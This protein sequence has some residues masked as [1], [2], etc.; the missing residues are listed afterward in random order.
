MTN[1]TIDLLQIKI[2]QAKAQLPAETLN[3]I[4]AVDWKSIILGL[5]EKKGYTF[6]QLGD[7]E[8][9]TELLLCG[10]ISTGDYT[11]EL[12]DRMGISEGGASELAKEMNDLVFRKIRE[13]LIKNEERKKTFQKSETESTANDALA[14]Q[15]SGI[16]IIRVNPVEVHAD[17]NKE[18]VVEDREEILKHIEKPETHL[19]LTPKLSGPVQ[20]PTVKTDHTLDNLSSSNPPSKPVI[21]SGTTKVDP[22]REIP[23]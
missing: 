19:L 21:N 2:E 18:K 11:K 8:L 10:L 1:D 23:E 22:Y 3:A 15:K 6:E 14:L 7:L 17:P 9:E 13:E 4:A 20:M 12:S 5:R 16:K